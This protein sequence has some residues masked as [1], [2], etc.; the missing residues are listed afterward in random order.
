[1]G[2][3][4]NWEQDVYAPEA[5]DRRAT[6]ALALGLAA[7]AAIG[8]GIAIQQIFERRLSRHEVARLKFLRYLRE[9]GH[10]ES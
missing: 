7:V 5:P 3:D 9:R 2:T 4:S 1:M 8:T 6:L 10:L